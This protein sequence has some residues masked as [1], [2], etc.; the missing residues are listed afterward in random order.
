[1]AAGT[2]APYAGNGSAMRVG[3]LGALYAGNLD[4]LVR[5]AEEQSSVTH[6]D[7]RCAAGAVAIA[8]A[9]ALAS[10]GRGLAP[11]ALL[12]TLAG[13]IEPLEPVTA[14]AILALAHWTGLAPNTAAARI[15]GLGL[16]VEARS[17]AEVFTPFVTTTVLWSLYA[18]LRSPDDYLESVST[19]I[20]GG[21]D[22]DTTAAMTGAIV[23]ARLGQAALPAALLPRLED[24]GAWR[25][26]EL[27]ALAR[28]SA[29]LVTAEIAG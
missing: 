14:G 24:R 27:D 26:D 22:T 4:L 12:E 25:A 3:P 23:G 2:P 11:R 19:A 18:F 21:G 16:A 13:W 17:P 8:G 10:P 6:R 1:M 9:A 15:H 29:A 28:Q 5:V 7:P 20:A